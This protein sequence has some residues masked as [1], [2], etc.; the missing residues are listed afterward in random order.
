MKIEWSRSTLWVIIAGVVLILAFYLLGQKVILAPYKEEV[1]EKEA[2]LT[3]EQ[4]ILSAIENN[5][6]GNEREQ[7]LTSRT[8]QQQLPVIPLMDQLLIGLDRAENASTSL[9]NS[10]AISDSES[11]IP[12][13]EPENEREANGVN[14]DEEENVD[15][16]V[17]EAPVEDEAVELIEGLHTLQLTVDVT[18]ENYDEM[19]SFMK[20]IQSLSRVIQIESI[21]FDAPESENELGYSIVLNSYYQPIY[22]NLAN[23]APQYHYG[24][25][26]NKVDPFAIEQ[27]DD[28]SPSTSTI[29]EEAADQESLDEEDLDRLEEDEEE[30]SDSESESQL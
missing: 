12:M 28:P 26:P 30:P 6:E 14:N 11:S 9:I 4:K 7:I 2:A 19:I 22:E 23:E 29:T 24:G 27:W 13:I 3:Q 20:E 5:Q 16:D 21:Q 17:V 1:V 15:K 10:M 25:S 18:S 8:I